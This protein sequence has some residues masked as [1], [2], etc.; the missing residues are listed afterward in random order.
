MSLFTVQSLQVEVVF[1]V[2][3]TVGVLLAIGM[4]CILATHACCRLL[5]SRRGTPWTEETSVDTASDRAMN[6]RR[7]TLVLSMQ[8]ILVLLV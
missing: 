7:C 4:P 6:C 8:I 3:L 2:C 5:A 1:I